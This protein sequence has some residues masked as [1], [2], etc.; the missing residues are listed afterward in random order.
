MESQRNVRVADLKA[1]DTLGRCTIV[2][3][4]VWIG[5]YMGSKNRMSVK[6]RYADGKEDTRIW[7]RDTT[8]KV[9]A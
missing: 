2:S 7:G 4:P 8:V 9:N 5:N 6:V 3:A 1:G